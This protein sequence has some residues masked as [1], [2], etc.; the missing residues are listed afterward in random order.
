MKSTR[1]TYQK[2]ST[3]YL[4]LDGNRNFIRG[5]NTAKAGIDFFIADNS[6]ITVSGEVGKSKSNAE[7]GG[8]IHNY[9]KSVSED[10]YSVSEN[11]SAR[12]NDFYSGT[13][14][15]QHKFNDSG[16]R[17][18]VM[19]FHSNSKGN[20][21]ES[22]D[23]IFTGSEYVKTSKFAS[24]ISSFE[25]EKES[26][27]RFKLD[28]MNPFTKTSRLEAGFQARMEKENQ[29]FSFR[30]YDLV[31]NI[32]TSNP[33]FSSSTDYSD[34]IYA[35][36]TTVSSKIGNLEYM[37]GLR[38]ELNN[39]SIKNSNL[40][41][42][43]TLNR[44]DLF[45]SFHVSYKSKETNEFMASYSRRVNRPSGRDLDP[46][47]GYMSR[48]T[49]WYGNP[50]LKPE[51]TD[52]YETGFL[53]R[54]GKSFASID[55]F[56]RVT[57]NKID[58]VLTIDQ[59]GIINMKPENFD[60]DFSTGLE[61]TANLNVTKW[62]LLN[63]SASMYNYRINGVL[64]GEEFNRNSTNWDGRMNAT[65]RVSS[66]GR[67]QLTGFFR[68]PSVS[69]Q[70]KSKSMLFT[71]ASYRYEFMD[72]KLSATISLQDI[73]GTA[74]FERE[75]YGDNFKS[76]F[77]MQREPRVFMLTLSY[78]INNFKADTRENATG[79]NRGEG[80]DFGIGM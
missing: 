71:N 34:N 61:L 76:W 29:N 79:S 59:N 40:Q 51:F 21:E 75:S 32:W 8:K 38:A 16:H 10:V 58:R 42:D 66:V 31:K 39:R 41:K 56:H 55:V 15:F 36:Y 43:A 17:L 27:T 65:A 24:R 30:D 25:D 69:A 78:K 80:M 57:H 63:S 77:K 62:L 45:P 53:K 18:E 60:R 22:E 19:A 72:K 46:T 2:D 64:N 6:T 28:Y 35:G 3:F 14:N 67:F 52:S 70:G 68:G 23:E 26:D 20:D 73:F 4:D 9:S 37:A 12:K 7:G 49:I 54:F 1:E 5:G 50:N 47:P 11:I 48:Y 33:L 44:F 74:K 13:L